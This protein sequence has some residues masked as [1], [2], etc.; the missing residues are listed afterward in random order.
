MTNARL[1]QIV[2]L[3]YVHEKLVTS[4]GI[5]NKEC[6]KL[7]ELKERINRESNY[8]DSNDLIATSFNFLSKVIENWI[9][10]NYN[11]NT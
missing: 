4:N 10:R 2:T 11:K 9:Q 1:Q 7:L 6:D 3:L 8:Y 5:K